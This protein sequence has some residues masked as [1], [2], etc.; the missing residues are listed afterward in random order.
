MRLGDFKLAAADFGRLGHG[1]HRPECVWVDADGIWVSDA[2]GG[3][4]G[5]P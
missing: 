5:F 3:V 4:S 2:R 1:L